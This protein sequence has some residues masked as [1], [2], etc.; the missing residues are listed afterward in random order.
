MKEGSE[1]ANARLRGAGLRP[2]RQR[3][4]LAALL[5]GHDSDVLTAEALH[6]LALGAGCKVSL[7]TVYGTLHCL[8]D[9]GLVREVAI[10]ARRHFDTDPKRQHYFYYEDERRL[11]GV[12][13]V[14]TGYCQSPMAPGGHRVSRAD[15]VV[16]L[17]RELSP[18]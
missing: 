16:R 17:K 14:E 2:T 18:L 9:A 11:V 4:E 12:T 1:V 3:L 6:I 10:D 7:A 13:E 8:R 15:V 5:F